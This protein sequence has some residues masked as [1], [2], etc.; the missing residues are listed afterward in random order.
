MIAENDLT[1]KQKA[2]QKGQKLLFDSVKHLTTL[3]T[4]SVLVLIALLEK[5]FKENQEWAFLIA[6]CIISFMASTLCSVF[7]M[8]VLSNSVFYLREQVELGSKKGAYVFY[9]SLFFFGPGVVSIVVFAL[10]N[11]Y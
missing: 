11:F 3:S 7:T 2:R 10:K 8:F 1:P 9:L 6:V 4:G 5:L